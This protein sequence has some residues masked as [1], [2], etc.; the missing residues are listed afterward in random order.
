METHEAI[1]GGE[2]SGGLTIAKHIKGKDGIFAAM[3][4]V[5]MVSVTGKQIGQLVNELYE[6]Y[7]SLYNEERDYPFSQ[8]KKMKLIIFSL[9]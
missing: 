6:E 2:S 7:G 9:N 1:I 4:L 8:K 5:E 3:L